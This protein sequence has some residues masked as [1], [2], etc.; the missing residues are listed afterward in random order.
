MAQHRT[1][2]VAFKRQVSQEHFGGETLRGL[3]KR[4]DL[5]RNL[6]WIW[7]EKFRPALWMKTSPPQTFCRS[8]RQASLRLS[9]L[10][11][12]RPS[13]WSF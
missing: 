9:G 13:N 7:V 11:D 3:S 10:S 5:S 8:T 1:Q 12:G 6:I 2:S 4:H